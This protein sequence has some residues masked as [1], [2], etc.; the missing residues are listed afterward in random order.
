MEYAGRYLTLPTLLYSPFTRYLPSLPYLPPYLTSPC[1]AEATN[2]RTG[3]WAQNRQAAQQ[4]GFSR[5]LRSSSRLRT[6]TL[7]A[8]F[9][10]FDAS[11]RIP[12]ESEGIHETHQILDGC[13]FFIFYFFLRYLF[14]SSCV[15]ATPPNLNCQ[16]H[17]PH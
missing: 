1:L 10:P 11:R 13:L 5:P 16:T 15:R 3:P 14:T 7:N 9:S 8:R 2:W 4:T 6:V 17:L 12:M